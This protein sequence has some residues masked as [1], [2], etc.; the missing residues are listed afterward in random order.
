MKVHRENPDSEEM[1]AATKA[2]ARDVFA[3]KMQARN[4]GDG[5]IGEITITK[6]EAALV[7]ALL[8]MWEAAYDSR[9]HGPYCCCAFCEAFETAGNFD[10]KTFRSL[11]EKCK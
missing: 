8:K 4:R 10:T 11:E 7:M 9:D 3:A 2:N 6:D 1:N 5:M